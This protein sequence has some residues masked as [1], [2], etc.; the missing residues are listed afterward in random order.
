MGIEK[1][2]TF[3]GRFGFGH[4]TGVDIAGERGGLLPSRAWKKRTRKQPWYPG[5]TLIVGI[6]Q[7]YFLTTPLQLA[8]ATATLAARGVEH[9]PRVV[10][11]ISSNY[12]PVALSNIG[13]PRTLQQSSAGNWSK[14][15]ESMTEVIEGRR[16]TARSLKN[17]NYR[18]AGKTGT[19]QVFTVKQDEEYDEEKVAKKMRDHALFVAFAPVDDPRIAVAVIVENGGHGGSVAA[20]IAKRIMDAHLLGQ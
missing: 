12:A 3:L 16:G 15:I 20:P 7:G 10:Q 9:P 6:G 19:A 17:E 1:L 11:N 2:Q 18:I 8:H 13:A 5:E 14:V 4:R